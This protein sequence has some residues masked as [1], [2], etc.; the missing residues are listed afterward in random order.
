M[1][2]IDEIRIHLE[3]ATAAHRKQRKVTALSTITLSMV[4]AAE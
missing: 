3:L 2:Y 4:I 1:G